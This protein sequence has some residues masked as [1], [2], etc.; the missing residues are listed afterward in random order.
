MS[1]EKRTVRVGDVAV[2]YGP[3]VVVEELTEGLAL[4]TAEGR[5]A[6]IP[7]EWLVPIHTGERGR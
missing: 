4:V 6:Q 7:V 5:I 1:T 3:L 2:V